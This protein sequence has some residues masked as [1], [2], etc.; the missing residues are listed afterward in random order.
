MDAV[1]ASAGRGDNLRAVVLASAG[2]GDNLDAVLAAGRGD[3]LD[4]VLAAGR[5]DN[6]DAVFAAGRGDNLPAAPLA[7]LSSTFLVGLR[8]PFPTLDAVPAGLCLSLGEAVSS[9]STSCT[10]SG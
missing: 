8:V 4:A 6:L 9:L 5:G 1:L 10:S 3:N 7:F 2:R